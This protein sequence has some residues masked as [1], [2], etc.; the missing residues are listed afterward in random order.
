VDPYVYD[1]DRGLKCRK[2]NKVLAKE[3][4]VC[5]ARLNIYH[6]DILMMIYFQNIAPPTTSPGELRGT[7][8]SSPSWP[9]ALLPQQ[10]VVP[11]V[12]LKACADGRHAG[13]S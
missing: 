2:D 5:G 4:R 12:L 11:L 13:Q 10:A 8:L 7:V 3:P 6:V 9:Y 1:F